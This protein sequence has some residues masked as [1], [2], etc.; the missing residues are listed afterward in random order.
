MKNKTEL[1]DGKCLVFVKNSITNKT[2]KIDGSYKSK[3]NI[4]FCIYHNHEEIIGYE[5]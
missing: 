5:Q 3:F 1:K 2:R 4:V